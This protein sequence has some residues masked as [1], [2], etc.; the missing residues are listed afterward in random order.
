M[1]DPYTLNEYQKVI[2]TFSA[3]TNFLTFYNDPYI[4]EG[5]ISDPY[6]TTSTILRSLPAQQVVYTY[7][8]LIPTMSAST[9]K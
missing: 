8:Y 6:I 7:E 4:L 9:N 3:S 1:N 5:K 2:P